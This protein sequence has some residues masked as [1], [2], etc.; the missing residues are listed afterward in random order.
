MKFGQKFY[1][2]NILQKN[3]KKKEKNH[4]IIRNLQ[5]HI[6]YFFNDVITVFECLIVVIFF[7]NDWLSKRYHILLDVDE[8]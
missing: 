2:N 8:L 7:T 6:F 1:S 5:D 3:I 4:D